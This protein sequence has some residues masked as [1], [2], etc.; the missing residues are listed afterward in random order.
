MTT[1]NATDCWL[2]QGQ[3]GEVVEREIWP[4]GI[5]LDPFGHPAQRIRARVVLDL[6][7]GWDAY[8][9]PT[10]RE[11]AARWLEHAPT[12]ARTVWVNGP[13]SGR[14]PLETAKICASVVFFGV[15]EILN[16]CLCAPGSAYW[17]RYVWPWASAV[18]WA[19]R[20]PFVAGERVA[21]YSPG[22]LAKGNRSSMAL[23]YY[24]AR[25]DAFERASRALGWPVSRTR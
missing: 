1:R 8:R 21:N 17:R 10:P 22:E 3:I 16:L 9:A 23:V 25:V 11:N 19:G 7:D 13:Y 4:E 15:P 2:T 20:L 12:G 5:G 24:G 6:R 14:F 18:A